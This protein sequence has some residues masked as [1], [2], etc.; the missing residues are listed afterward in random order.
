MSEDEFRYLI[1]GLVVSCDARLPL[2]AVTTGSPDVVY[3]V[4]LGHE[5]PQLNHRRSDDPDDPWA[6]E[7]WFEGGQAVEFPG[8]ATFEYGSEH[9]TLVVDEIDDPE[10]VA[11]LL[12]DHVVPRVVALRGDLMLHA[13]GAVGP[14]GRAHLFLGKAAAGKSTIVTRLALGRWA[15]LDDDGVRV[16]AAGDGTFRA[17]PGTADVRLLPDIADRLLAGVPPGAR[18]S[19]GSTKRRYGAVAGAL[20]VATRPAPVAALYVLDRDSDQPP[21]LEPLGFA[22]ALT[23][24]ARHGF[25]VAED[26]TDIARLAF[27]RGAG[28]AAAVPV[29]RLAWP[30]GMSSLGATVELIEALDKDPRNGSEEVPVQ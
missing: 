23:S 2:P 5:L 17:F 25:H 28:L 12:V 3:R 20:G 24:I 30:S 11:H 1:H 13:S 14:S 8:R 26:P 22:E 19:A 21:S 16:A 6:I 27:E 10:H 18:T 15:L 7:C 29:R 4:D 9:V